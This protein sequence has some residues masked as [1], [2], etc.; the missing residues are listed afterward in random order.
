MGLNSVSGGSVSLLRLN[1]F[2][3]KTKYVY[4]PYSVQIDG[5]VTGERKLHPIGMCGLYEETNNLYI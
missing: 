5:M 4:R 3:N 2:K 1:L